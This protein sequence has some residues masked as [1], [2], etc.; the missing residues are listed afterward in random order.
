MALGIKT[1]IKTALL[2]RRWRKLNQHNTTYIKAPCNID[3]ISVG[4]GT[5]GGVCAYHTGNDGKLRIGNWCSIAPEVCFVFNNEHA[6]ATLSSYP[7]KAKALHS[8]PIEAISKGGITVEDD[9]WLGCRSMILDGVTIGQG[10]VVAAGAVVT[11]DVPPYTIVG[12]VPAKPIKKRFDD[13]TID[14]LSTIDLSLLD[15]DMVREHLDF[16]YTDVSNEMLDDLVSMLEV[17][18]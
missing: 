7:F 13:E 1:A 11:K 8:Q 4:K 16:I 17:H 15:K 18:K 14:F 3:L 9:V 6:L 10:A 5:Y 2:N 12:G